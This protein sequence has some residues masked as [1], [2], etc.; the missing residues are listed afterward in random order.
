VAGGGLVRVVTAA[1]GVEVRVSWLSGGLLVGRCRGGR[2]RPWTGGG[3]AIRRE[4]GAKAGVGHGGTETGA[5]GGTQ[6]VTVARFGGTAHLQ[7]CD[8]ARQPRGFL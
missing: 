2:R 7:T 5:A 3:A 1:S 8:D 4:T 6:R